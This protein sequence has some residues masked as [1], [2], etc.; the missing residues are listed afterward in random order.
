MGLFR[1]GRESTSWELSNGQSVHTDI[2][3]SR[4]DNAHIATTGGTLFRD[5]TTLCF[6]RC[7]QERRRKRFCSNLFALI[8]TDEKR[9]ICSSSSS[10][11]VHI[12]SIDRS[13]SHFLNTHNSPSLQTRYCELWLSSLSHLCAYRNM[14]SVKDGGGAGGALRELKR[15]SILETIETPS[16][17]LAPYGKIKLH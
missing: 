12:H 3:S 1:I 6:G 11:S 10:C 9:C 5:K 14:K 4:N 15:E 16:F 8:S 2:Q 17:R 7:S 13:Q